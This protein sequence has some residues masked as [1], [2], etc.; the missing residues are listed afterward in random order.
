MPTD[1]PAPI[2]DGPEDAL[3]RLTEWGRERRSLARRRDPLVQAALQGPL[4]AHGGLLRTEEATALTAQTLRRIKDR[5]GV[6]VLARDTSAEVD[7]DGYA[8]YLAAE[9]AMIREALDT[10]PSSGSR[11]E[12]AAGGLR[13]PTLDD[14]R[15]RLLQHL[16]ERVR[17]TE[18]SDYGY[19]SLTMELRGDAEDA[20]I[21][22][23]VLQEDSQGGPVSTESRAQHAQ[24]LHEVADQITAFRREGEAAFDHLNPAVLERARADFVAPPLEDLLKDGT[25]HPAIPEEP[26]DDEDD[27]PEDQL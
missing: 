24:I 7:W 3:D 1:D 23:L 25:D 9:S 26:S 22:T 21:P 12:P 15:A 16:S 10:L 2:L 5:A 14:L 8:D 18:I 20:Q 17:E 27:K 19:W 4:A 6:T 11:R 13:V